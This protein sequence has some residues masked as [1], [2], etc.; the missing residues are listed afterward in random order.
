MNELTFSSYEQMKSKIGEVLVDMC[1]T[2][3]AAGY[4]FKQAKASG[5][6]RQAGY[7][8]FYDFIEAEFKVDKSRAGRWMQINDQYSIGG[9][10]TDI[11]P[12]YE[13]YGETKL[14]EMISLPQEIRDEIPPEASRESIREAKDIMK[15]TEEEQTVGYSIFDAMSV[16]TQDNNSTPVQKAIT[17]IFKIEKKN[18]RKYFDLAKKVPGGCTSTHEDKLLFAIVPNGFRMMH[19]T[20]G[21]VIINRSGLKLIEQRIHVSLKEMAEQ[22]NAM[23][24]QQTPDEAYKE[25]YGEDLEVKVKTESKPQTVQTQKRVVVHQQDNA[26]QEPAAV[27]ETE[28]EELGTEPLTNRSE[29]QASE[30]AAGQE[31]TIAPAQFEDGTLQGY[32]AGVTNALK[33]LSFIWDNK[34]VNE[35]IDKMIRKAEDLT[36][37]L[38]KIKESLNA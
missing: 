7:E 23:F 29:P 26:P 38:K 2:Y 15:K 34:D 1:H 24:P 21:N 5:L 18:F 4:I 14:I 20:S 12:Q 10:S 3:V 31:E 36:W 19:L 27:Q 30:P 22:F 37:R 25:I 11:L 9:N 16:P 32:K 13:G 33:A 6:W 35:E 8:S 28:A 17:E